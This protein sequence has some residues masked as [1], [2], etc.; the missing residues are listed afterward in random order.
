M[1]RLDLITAL[2]CNSILGVLLRGKHFYLR[3]LRGSQCVSRVVTNYV[4]HNSKNVVKI[5]KKILVSHV[6]IT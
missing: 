5:Q 1:Y 4:L 2:A 6:T 3:T